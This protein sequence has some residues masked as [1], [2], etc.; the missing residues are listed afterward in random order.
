VLEDSLNSAFHVL[1][2][3]L[4]CLSNKPTC[5]RPRTS[6]GFLSLDSQKINSS[7]ILL[8]SRRL[9]Y[10]VSEMGGTFRMSVPS[11]PPKRTLSH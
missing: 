10:S 3:I 11:L 2:K 5:Q 6:P 9:L 7:A 8:F 1:R 4:P